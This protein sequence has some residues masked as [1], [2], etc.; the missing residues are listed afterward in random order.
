[1]E[2][3]V[4]R[5]KAFRGGNGLL[6]GL[7]NYYKLGEAATNARVDSHG[8]DDLD[9]LTSDAGNS[10]GKDGNGYLVDDLSDKIGRSSYVPVSGAGARSVF[11]WVNP[12]SLSTQNTVFSWGANATGTRFTVRVDS[13]NLRVEIQGSGYT[14]SLAV[15]TGSFHHIGITFDGTQLQDCTLWVNGVSEAAT[16]TTTIDTSGGSFELNNNSAGNTTGFNGAV[17]DEV[18]IWNLKLT[19]DNI[20]DLYGA[21]SGLFYD[22]FD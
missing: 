11:S 4:N 6:S 17:I 9:V 5:R 12:S 14:S 15:S 2:Y 16:G 21:G 10:T 7:L 8:T 22:S 3:F 19:N 18:S 13:G 20:A 1:M